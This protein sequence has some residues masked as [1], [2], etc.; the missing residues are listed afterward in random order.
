MSSWTIPLLLFFILPA[1]CVSRA[2]QGEVGGLYSIAGD[3]TGYGVVKVIALDSGVVHVRLYANT[4]S[5]RPTTLD[6]ASLHLGKIG[7]PGGIGIGHLPLTTDHFAAWE[8]KLI[9]R[10]PV[11]DDELD[12]YREWK[13]AGGGVWGR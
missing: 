3:S 13:A 10:V 9:S 4:F 7:E 1:G 12:G 8:P 5:E 11:T 6:P 2:P